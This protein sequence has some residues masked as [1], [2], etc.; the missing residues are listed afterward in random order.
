MLRGS[1]KGSPGSAF[2]WPADLVL[3]AIGFSGPEQT[4]VEK[5]GL[6]TDAKSNIKA[7]YGKFETNVEGVFV[8]GDA[9]RGASL[10]V[11]AIAEG[12]EVAREIDRYLMGVTSLP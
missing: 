7:E 8:A 9:R 12:R 4:V 2:D 10:I 5:L 3:L 6:A 11:W 1:G